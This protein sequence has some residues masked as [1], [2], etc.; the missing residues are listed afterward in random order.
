MRHQI[1]PI[2]ALNVAEAVHR[3]LSSGL[4]IAIGV[5]APS[6]F[7]ISAVADITGAILVEYVQEADDFGD[8]SVAVNVQDL[9]LVSDDPADVLLSIWSFEISDPGR[10]SYFQS[11]TSSSWL[12]GNMGGPFDTPALRLA[13]S[14]VTIGGFEQG[15]ARPQQLPGSGARTGTYCFASSDAYPG[16][17][18]G[19]YN[20][21]PPSHNGQVGVIPDV[22]G[23]L[24]G[25]GVLVGRFAFGTD[26]VFD[27][28]GSAFNITWNQ[29]VGTAGQQMQVC[30][31]GSDGGCSIFDLDRNFMIDGGD[32]GLWL[33]AQAG[34]CAVING[35]F[36]GDG[37]LSGADLGLLLNAWGSCERPRQA[38][39]KTSPFSTSVVLDDGDV[40]E[41]RITR[42]PVATTETFPT[43]MFAA[44]L[45]GDGCVGESDL[46]LWRRLQEDRDMTRADLDGDGEVT[47]GDLGVLLSAWGQCQP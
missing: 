27:L 36:N 35:D 46:A 40:V 34:T 15:V 6:A 2:V 30:L 23:G 42:F 13:D 24:D 12:A 33:S 8:T 28:T 14:F 19:W 25:L 37:E 47:G 45:D 39:P 26:C 44:D 29:G 18:A 41:A 3:N 10:V 20:G 17:K 22:G 11:F 5:A 1:R 38:N 21:S 7:G 16:W 4:A 32:L 43:V 31:C 9:Y